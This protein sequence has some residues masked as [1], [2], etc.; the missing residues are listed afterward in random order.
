MQIPEQARSAMQ[1]NT[2]DGSLPLG[3][4]ATG[5]RTLIDTISEIEAVEKDLKA[6][7][8]DIK[9]TILRRMVAAGAEKI[10]AGGMSLTVGDK[11]YCRIDGERWEEI[12]REMSGSEIAHCLYRQIS[13]SKLAE[14]VLHGKR[15]PEGITLET[16]PTLNTRRV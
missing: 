16:V 11:T 15:L 8:D 1:V 6:K 2:T 5:L 4:L 13:A 12:V 14:E 7:R 3:D 9:E 10:T